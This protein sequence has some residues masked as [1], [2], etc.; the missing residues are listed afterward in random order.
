MV[1]K[2]VAEEGILKGLVLNLEHGDQWVI[3]R[4]PEEC[5]LLV[6][7]PSASRKHML[8]RSTPEGILAENLSATNPIQINEEEVTE[9]MVLHH[10]D[11]VKIGSG[12]FRFY[13]EDN[14]SVD[15]LP[16]LP[17]IERNPLEQ[18]S[19]PKLEEKKDSL[20]E[21]DLGDEAEN[22]L[23]HVNLELPETTGWMLK[24]VAG[25]NNGA[26]FIMQPNASYI[27][28]TDPASCDIVFQDVSVSRQHARLTIHSDES[29]T[30]EDL[31]SSNG[32]L[33]EGRKIE[34]SQQLKPNTFISLGTSSFVVYNL[35]GERTT[36]ISPLLP[37]IV[38]MLQDEEKKKE[39]E[40]HPEEEIVE[41]SISPKTEIRTPEISNGLSKKAIAILVG[42]ILLFGVIGVSTLF[43]SHEVTAPQR[44]PNKEIEAVIAPYPDLKFSYFKE[45][46]RLFL[47]GHVLTNSDK[48]RLI[49][50]LNIMPFVQDIDDRIIVDENIWNETNQVLAK[51]PNWRGIATH[52]PSAGK[53]VISGYIENKKQAEALSD[54]L[55]Q[56]FPYPDLLEKRIV[57]DEEVASQIKVMLFERGFSDVNAHV[58]GGEIVLEGAMPQG[59]KE[60]LNALLVD[61]KAINGVRSVKNFIAELPAEEAL[62]NISAKYPVTGSLT[63]GKNI[64]VVLRGRIYSTGDLLDGM[65]ITEIGSN[66]IYLE[67]DGAKYVIDYNR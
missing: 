53:F 49:Y 31:K 26:E 45:T 65:K 42:C 38:K 66:H 44:D 10:G 15:T 47:T 29:F 48:N 24:V 21:E 20:F 3:G 60:A 25:P 32:T 57:I 14:I 4:D 67:K 37:A 1:A 34:T 7:D 39:K 51:N 59:N 52:S 16:Q 23:P 22:L 56:N 43:R 35:E 12:I 64:S 11:A 46:G 30:I 13:S 19:S 54:Y 18:P 5:Q 61:I 28:G 2:L 17:E 40:R 58:S 9:P 62:E 6:E 55:T 33:V 27:L 50:N 41:E 8:C 36:V 63:Q